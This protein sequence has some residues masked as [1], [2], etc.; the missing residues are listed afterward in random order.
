MAAL[1]AAAC[2]S[3]GETVSSGAT[4]SLPG[5]ASSSGTSPGS[6]KGT[7]STTEDDD[8]VAEDAIRDVDFATFT[9]APD[10]CGDSSQGRGYEV[11]DGVGTGDAAVSVDVGSIA[12]GDVTGDGVEDAVVLFTCDSGGSAGAVVPLVYT[13]DD[14][15]EPERIGKLTSVDRA[16]VEVTGAAIISGQ[17]HTEE[18]VFGPEDPR[19][20][21]SG[22]GSTIWDWVD[23][24]FVVASTT[25]SV[26]TPAPTTL[27]ARPAV[28]PFSIRVDGVGPFFLGMTKE[29]L[30]ANGVGVVQE[31]PTC[32]VS[33]F[34]AYD[35]PDGLY[36]VL[37]EVGSVRAIVVS[38]PAYLTD[39]NASVDS[40][41][42][43]LQAVYPGLEYFSY[44]VDGQYAVFS[45]DRNTGIYFNAS[46]EEIMSIIVAYGDD[47]F[48]DLC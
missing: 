42:L 16:E 9:Y 10:S 32:G 2:S 7:T 27:P 47:G 46:G 25:T 38:S 4:T 17:I 19:C 26:I 40:F 1:G 13:V 18:V 24:S 28:D 22:S 8:D 39:A 45:P 35:A 15:G 29:E 11:V 44:G 21:P 30:T 3:S 20:C 43:D 48:M 6:A 23:G 41:V 33:P 34:E 5:M 14:A 12:Y 31:D 36:F 37:D